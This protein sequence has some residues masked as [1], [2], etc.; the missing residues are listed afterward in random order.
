VEGT[1]AEGAPGLGDDA[2][3]VH[4]EMVEALREMVLRERRG[5]WW[6]EIFL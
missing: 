3:G 6:G 4:E 2:V 1:L 5:T